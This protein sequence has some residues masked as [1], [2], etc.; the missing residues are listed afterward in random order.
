MDTPSSV[1]VWVEIMEVQSL[2][3]SGIPEWSHSM[4]Q[5]SVNKKLSLRTVNRLMELAEVC[6][7]Y[8]LQTLPWLTWIECCSLS[9]LAVS[10][11]DR[12]FMLS[13]L[14][15][16]LCSQLNVGLAHWILSRQKMF[17]SSILKLHTEVILIP[18]LLSS[19][20][21]SLSTLP[22]NFPLPPH[23]HPLLHLPMTH[24]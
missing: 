21:S 2:L 18:K 1:R 17:L 4:A 6:I 5:H 8:L 24:L 22:L 9:V 13:A 19:S 20:S 15:V 23:R 12:M 14:M 10:P 3:T 11:M 7:S 16:P